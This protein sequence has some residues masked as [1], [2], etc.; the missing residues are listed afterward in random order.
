MAAAQQLINAI[1][2]GGVW[3]PGSQTILLREIIGGGSEDMERHRAEQT[4]RALHPRLKPHAIQKR[5]APPAPDG[6]PQW[7]TA[8][9]WL[10]EIDFVLL[11]G[12]RNGR[13]G[14]SE[15]IERICR[16]WVDLESQL[17]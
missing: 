10:R 5:I 4:M 2:A 13:H 3:L 15:V 9:F 8:E 11:E 7:R 16:T 6:S 17:L 14:Q 12:I 1:P